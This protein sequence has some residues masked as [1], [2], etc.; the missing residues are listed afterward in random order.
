MWVAHLTVG[1][2]TSG[3]GG[4]GFILQ[5][6]AEKDHEE[7]ASKHSS[8]PITAAPAFC[9]CLSFCPESLQS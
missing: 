9:F 8:V 4:L 6:K 7:Q 2:I 3:I 5:Q 1:G